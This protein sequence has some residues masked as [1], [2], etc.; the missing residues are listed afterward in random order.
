MNKKITNKYV[1]ATVLIMLLA[2]VYYLD[3][4]TYIFY[5]HTNHNQIEVIVVTHEECLEEHGHA[6]PTKEMYIG[7]VDD[8]VKVYFS[9]VDMP[10]VGGYVRKSAFGK[11]SYVMFE[12]NSINIEVIAHEALHIAYN[13]EARKALRR[14]DE[15][16]L[17]YRVGEITEE[18][19]YL[20][21]GYER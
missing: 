15:E 10:C 5:N 12:A 2:V 7:T 16:P 13:A 11:A 19:I 1:V 14:G 20:L 6:K 8:D 4:K 9:P 21:A 17:A 18:L 3:Y